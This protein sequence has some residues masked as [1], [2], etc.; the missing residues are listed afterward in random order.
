MDGRHSRRNK[1]A[2]SNFSGVVEE[3]FLPLQAAKGAK[4]WYEVLVGLARVTN[5]LPV[6]ARKC[7]SV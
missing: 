7:L 4:H 3:C 5:A 6:N 1:A 2:F